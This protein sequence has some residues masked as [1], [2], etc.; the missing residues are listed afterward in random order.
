MFVSNHIDSQ[1]GNT[2]R[3]IL[4]LRVQ[5]VTIRTLIFPYKRRPMIRSVRFAMGQHHHEENLSV[6]PLLSRALSR[7][8]IA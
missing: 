6:Q 1:P 7:T 4:I 2:M 5:L 3:T 8:T